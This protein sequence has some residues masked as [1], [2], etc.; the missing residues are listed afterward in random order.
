MVKVFEN[1]P[2]TFACIVAIDSICPKPI[3]ITSFPIYP[4]PLKPTTVPTVP[5]VGVIL[6]ICGTIRNILLAED[7]YIPFATM[8]HVPKTCVFAV[9]LK[10]KVPFGSA[11]LFFNISTVV[12]KSMAIRSF[13]LYPLPRIV[14]GTPMVPLIGVTP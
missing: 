12:P 11:K 6:Y 1:C 4:L 10:T 9:K 14:I 5:M 3:F 13:A 7:E 2:N 8:V